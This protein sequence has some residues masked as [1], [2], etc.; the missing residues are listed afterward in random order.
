M[1][2]LHHSLERACSR[3]LGRDLRMA[4]L[5]RLSA[6]A[7][8]ET[9]RAELMDTSWSAPMKVVIQL[10]A[11]GEQYAGAL[12]KRAQGL[13]Q[14][15]AHAAG[16]PTPRV[17][18]VFDEEDAIGQGFV[19]EWQP[20]ETLGHRIVHD[21]EFSDARRDL[22]RQCAAALAKIHRLNPDRL[23]AL[24]TRSSADSVRSLAQSCQA[25]DEP[26]PIFELTLR[27]LER[28][29]P[30]VVEPRLVHG[31]FRIGNLLIEPT[32]GLRAVLDWEMA[33]LGDPAEDLGW[34]MVNAW[35]FGASEKKV[36]GIGDFEDLRKS[37]EVEIG[38]PVDPRVVRFW[39]VFGTLQWGMM[40]LWF[41]RQFTSGSV[42]EIERVAIGRRISEV[43][44][45]LMNLLRDRD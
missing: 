22:I 43:Q 38:Y 13:V 4:A 36:G 32:I 3:H 5:T 16:V 31:D 19:S 21:V 45:D 29:Q 42:R 44:V 7:S 12:D 25:F 34:L 33:H 11:G 37:Y 20:G 6:G 30:P 24:P 35:R 23:P 27:W 26:M 2:A 9:W 14:R 8:S 39:R 1:T 41:V 18:C 40:C 10:F 17:L 28:N 15:A